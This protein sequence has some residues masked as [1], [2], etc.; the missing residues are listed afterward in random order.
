VVSLA[1]EYTGKT[2]PGELL[3]PPF[4]RVYI[5]AATG[6]IVGANFT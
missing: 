1:S 3:V 5:D 6:E 2:E 4:F